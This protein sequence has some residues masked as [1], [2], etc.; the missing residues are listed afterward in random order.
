MSGRI[1]VASRPGHGTRFTI[2][3][4]LLHEDAASQTHQDR[5]IG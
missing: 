3:L 4:P 1:D 2:S 5:K